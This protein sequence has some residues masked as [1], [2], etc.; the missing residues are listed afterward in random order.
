MNSDDDLAAR[1][2]LLAPTIDTDRAWTDFQA[3]R[4][5]AARHR[6]S[7]RVASGLAAAAVVLVAVVVAQ[8]ASDTDVVVVDEPAPTTPT[9][10]RP[11]LELPA[12]LE[13]ETN[14]PPD[15]TYVVHALL[16]ADGTTDRVSF[17]VDD[18][19]AGFHYEAIAV[20]PA[21]RTIGLPAAARRSPRAA[22]DAASATRRA[23]G[24]TVV[25]GVVV[26]FDNV[27]KRWDLDTGPDECRR[28]GRPYDPGAAGG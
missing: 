7:R 20:D 14:I 21:V 28:S 1:L 9:T 19:S 15:G 27:H 8:Q 16:L 5:R 11:C 13:R 18:S 25:D 23:I 4:V 12:G 17:Y 24:I 2:A 26:A 3:A 10:L 6:R 22:I